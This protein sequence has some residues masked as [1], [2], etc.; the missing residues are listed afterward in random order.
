M[1]HYP[2]KPTE[3]AYLAYI[4][5]LTSHNGLW[6]LS[7]G[8]INA[9]SQTRATQCHQYDTVIPECLWQ[10]GFNHKLGNPTLEFSNASLGGLHPWGEGL[11]MLQMAVNFSEFPPEVFQDLLQGI[12]NNHRGR[13][14]V[15][16]EE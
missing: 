8:H 3:L 9:V 10:P 1:V 7:G 4:N 13:Y 5:S 16:L 14:T 6:D 12:V 15:T 2:I 11:C